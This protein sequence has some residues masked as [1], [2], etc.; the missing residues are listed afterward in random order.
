MKKIILLS[1]LT[2]ASFSNF[3]AD[4]SVELAWN[5]KKSVPLLKTMP[6]PKTVFSQ[7]IEQGDVKGVFVTQS[8]IDGEPAKILHLV[9]SAKNKAAVQ[10]KLQDFPV[11]QKGYV[12]IASI[13]SLGAKWLDS[14]P[15]I[16]RTVFWVSIYSE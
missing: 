3:A 6:K 13:K 10:A 5:T 4:Y 15:E 11:F 2:L 1:I 9:L 8:P 14:N 12:K 7:M 16:E